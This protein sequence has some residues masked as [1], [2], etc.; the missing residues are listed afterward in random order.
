M[1]IP[2]YTITN[3]ILRNIGVIEASKEII[4]TATIISAWESKLR[5]QALEKTIYFSVRMEGNKLAEDEVNEILEGKE[6]I[7]AD[8]DKVEVINTQRT[9][10]YLTDLANISFEKPLDLTWQI[11]SDIHT[12]LMERLMPP[13]QL[14]KLRSSQIVVKNVSSG[15]ISY[16]P[17]PGAEVEYLLEDA[18]NWLNS[19]GRE[20][21][22]VIRA[23]IAQMEIYRVHPFR[24]GNAPVGRA[25]SDLILKSEGYGIKEF[26]SIEEYFDETLEDY[27]A[28]LQ[29]VS[30]QEVMDSFE[31]DLTEWIDYFVLGAAREI[32]KL[33]EM[34]K[35]IST[36][37]KVKD[38]LGESLIL[39]ERQMIIMDYL[40]RHKSMMNKDFRKIFP[41]FSDDTVL[42]ELKFLKKKG[43]VNKLGTTKKA[44]YVPADLKE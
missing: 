14:G 30:G 6:T 29:K 23:A 39:T 1:L 7:A 42:R 4:L 38:Q 34:V 16:S 5:R 10:K 33:K 36:E 41:D 44:K 15:E 19:D 18:L 17:P 24:E 21:H 27:H 43:L 31:R 20:T 28:I 11:L 3:S 9:Y 22:P 13:E 2:K 37:S 32:V 26:L 25:L 40:H 12:S 35:K 8:V